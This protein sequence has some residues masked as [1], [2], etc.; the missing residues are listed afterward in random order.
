MHSLV[1]ISVV[2]LTLIDLPGLTKIAI[3]GQSDSIV[4]EIENMV[5]SYIE[6]V[7]VFVDSYSC[8]SFWSL[9]DLVN[10]TSLCATL[11]FD[12]YLSVTL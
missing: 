6:K 8:W 5:R 4:G 10:C 12:F 1:V 2:N 7:I 11:T 9:V 3:E